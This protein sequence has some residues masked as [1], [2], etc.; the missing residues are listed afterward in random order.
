[1]SFDESRIGNWYSDTI[2]LNGGDGYQSVKNIYRTKEECEAAI[3]EL[4]AKK[5]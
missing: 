5:K 3:A 4:E 2:E 1:M